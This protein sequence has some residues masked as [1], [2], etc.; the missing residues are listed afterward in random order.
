MFHDVR[1]AR[2]LQRPAP[3]IVSKLAPAPWN[4]PQETRC[5]AAK[6]QRLFRPQPSVMITS[7]RPLSTCVGVW[8]VY[9]KHPSACVSALSLLTLPSNQVPSTRHDACGNHR[10]D[11]RCRARSGRAILRPMCMAETPKFPGTPADATDAKASV[12]LGG[13]VLAQTIAAH[14]GGIV[15][16][17]VLWCIVRGSVGVRGKCKRA[18]VGVS[19][20]ARASK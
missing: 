14:G 10:R 16:E 4:L 5:T 9:Y 1:Q 6:N 7:V 18:Q 3:W 19:V 20:C 17:R 13:L 11:G 12:G 15:R 2:S 8:A